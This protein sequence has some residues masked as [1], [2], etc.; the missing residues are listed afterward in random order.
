MRIFGRSIG[1]GRRHSPRD[2]SVLLAEVS[3]VEDDRRVALLNISR[4]GARLAAPDLPVKGADI[5]LRAADVEAF[6]HVIWSQA[7]Q[8]GVLFE[9]SIAA[10]AVVALREQEVRIAA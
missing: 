3:T 7:G 6:G 2:P 10:S 1:G 4:R 8:C 9:P 5:I